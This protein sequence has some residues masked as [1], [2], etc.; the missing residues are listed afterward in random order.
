MTHWPGGVGGACGQDRGEDPPAFSGDAGR[1]K[2]FDTR[3][4]KRAR[5]YTLS[6]SFA[7][8]C[9]GSGG[10]GGGETGTESGGDSGSSTES[11]GASGDGDAGGDGD[12]DAGGSA[13][14]GDGDG[15]GTTGAPPPDTPLDER[16]GVTDLTV[17]AGVASGDG[18]WR[19]WGRGDLHV[20]PVYTVPLQGCG[21]LI[22]Y[23]GDDGVARVAQ[24]DGA[25][26]LAQ[27]HEI[28]AGVECRGLA[29]EPDG[30]FAA[31]LWDEGA[32]AIR[33]DRFEAD[34]TPSWSTPLVNSDNTP[35]D[36]GIGDS[37]M[38]YGG[39]RYGAYY[40][41]HSNDG[42]EGDTLKWADAATG[43]ESTEWAWGCSHSMSNVLRFNGDVGEF[44]P[45][46]VTDC[47]PGTS[48]DFSTNAIGGIYV[49]HRESKIMDVDAG[50]NGDVA[51]E[52][53]SGAPMASGWAVVFNAH[54]DPAGMGQNSHDPNVKDQ[55]VGFTVVS[56]S[57]EAGAVV[58]LTDTDGVHETDPSIARLGEGDDLVVGWGEGPLNEG[59]TTYWLAR[60]GPDG[61]MREG[62]ID[63][64][65][66]VQ[67]GR[68]DDPFR[69]SANGD[70]VWA[71]FDAPGSTTLHV[72]RVAAGGACG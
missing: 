48:G 46:C 56:G 45:V 72:A 21:T 17:P 53:G 67:W 41:V 28:G 6:F 33:I 10:D 16:L 1:A 22:C 13:G 38:D 23:T 20:A 26:T 65:A 2:V 18:N 47:F 37:R 34:G 19:I 40:H 62:P 54:A 32:T 50:C 5:L 58:W 51:G 69:R 35:T 59:P 8:A 68:R 27:T 15:D 55:D 29:A 36:F 64:T 43:A 61:T 52:L 4:V 42:H 14:D 63:V 49:D 31:L 71:W 30:S 3:P 39:G 9:G 60:V 44:L 11:G 12:G 70:V 24:L 7:L 66:T 25:D 57:M